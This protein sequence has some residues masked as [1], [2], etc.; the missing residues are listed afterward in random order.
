MNTGK[1]R[2]AVLFLLELFDSAH[3]VTEKVIWLTVFITHLM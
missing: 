2:E 3:R 1:D